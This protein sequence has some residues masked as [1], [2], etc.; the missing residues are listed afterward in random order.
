LADIDDRWFR[1][2]KATGRKVPAARHGKGKRWD[3][4]WRD[5]ERQR[6]RA[7]AKK[8]DAER[9]LAEVVADLSRGTYVD[10]A[11]GR[12]TV[13]EYGERWRGEQ[14]HR[15]STADRV[16]RTLRLHVF[17]I[18]GHLRMG[19]VRSSHLQAW[20]KDRSAVMAPN[21]LHVAYS[22]T[23]VPMFR[24]AVLDR[25]IGSTPCTDI[26]LPEVDRAE[27]FIPT[28]AQ[29]HALA[30]ALPERYRAAVYLAAGCGLRAGELFGLEVP[31]VDFLRRELH[32]TQQ[33]TMRRARTSDGERARTRLAPP[34][35]KTSR[36]TV[37]LL[38]TVQ[39]ALAQHL[40]RFPAELVELEDATDPRKVAERPA[41][42]LF[43][44]ERG[45]LVEAW[46]WTQIWAPAARTVGLPPRTGLHCLR[47]FFATSL[48]EA[49][50]S[51]KTVQ[52][53]LG[54]S[55]PMVTL[56]PTSGCGPR[57]STGP[58]PSSTRRLVM[59][60]R[61]APTTR[62]PDDRC[63]SGLLQVERAGVD[64]IALARWRGAVV[65]DVAEVGAATA[66]GDLDAG[67]A[68]AVVG[69]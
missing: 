35:S 22:G 54:H 8:S 9:Y 41:R 59:C 69:M 6:H 21:T 28:P 31:R 58:A 48:I 49:G 11:A 19:Q 2:D 3:V 16:E 38:N 36:R 46:R 25:V 47:H 12:V 17:P 27:H 4:R 52:L 10:H 63:W 50:A 45:E 34:K 5:G 33:L 26:R 61:C 66:A 43:T 65:E 24:R 29:V 67:H 44:A 14:L 30:D 68:V 60:A 64:A 13:A 15:D 39:L 62:R 32:V 23:L 55:T 20:V 51:V 53:A 40:E 42:L 56:T 18:L 1:L 7:Y 57:W 37:E